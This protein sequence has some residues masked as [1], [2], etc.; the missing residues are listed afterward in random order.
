MFGYVLGLLV[1]QT[2]LAASYQH[3]SFYPYCNSPLSVVTSMLLSVCV[4]W[5]RSCVMNTPFI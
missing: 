4:H 1:D 5:K 2:Y 3:L